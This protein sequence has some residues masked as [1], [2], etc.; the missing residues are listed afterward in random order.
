MRAIV[1][2]FVSVG[3]RARSEKSSHGLA[4]QEKHARRKWLLP[5]GTPLSLSLSQLAAFPLQALAAS[6]VGGR[7][8]Y[9]RET[10]SIR[11][12]GGPVLGAEIRM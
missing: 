1:R 11:D 12:L 5:E 2:T 4:A 6:R 7:I 9:H 10:G 8:I 3:A